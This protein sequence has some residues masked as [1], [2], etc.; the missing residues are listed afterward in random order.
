MQTTPLLDSSTLPDRQAAAR[1]ALTALLEQL[2]DDHDALRQLETLEHQLDHL[3]AQNDYL[4][5]ELRATT[6]SKTEFISAMTHELRIPMTSIK[7]YTDM[8]GMIGTLSDQQQQFVEIIRSNVRRMSAQLSDLSDISRLE[9]NRL[10]LDI[11]DGVKLPDVI[12]SAVSA[13][14]VE[15]E[16][17]EH[18]LKQESAPNLPTVRADA[19]RLGQVVAILLTNAVRYTP[20]GGSIT[21]KSY[22]QGARVCCAVSDTGVG[23]TP[24]EMDNLFTKFW[25][26]DNRHV[27][28]QPGTGLELVI[29]RSLIAMHGGTLQVT[30]KKDEGSTFTFCLPASR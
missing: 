16:R 26:A 22:R 8:L 9:S 30:S 24:D 12:D 17:F 15:I 7:G 20:T 13:L 25:R 5:D 23:M 6:R 29:A 3:T 10:K 14:Q 28:E 11:E 27:R 18:K 19:Q 2:A 4:R 1:A 21:I